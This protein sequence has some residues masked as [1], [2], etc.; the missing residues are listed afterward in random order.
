MRQLTLATLL[1]GGLLAGPLLTPASAVTVEELFSLKANGLSDDILMA[2]IES[3]GSV[4][5][6]LPEDVVTLYRRGLSERVILTMIGTSRR[7][8]QSQAEAETV[9]PIRTQETVVQP[10]QVM[11][12][13]SPVE[14]YVP[15][16]VPVNVYVPV[17]SRRP[18]RSHQPDRSTTFWGFGGQLRPDAWAQPRQREPEKNREPDRGRKDDDRNPAPPARRR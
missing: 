6:L 7:V 16:A 2:L 4:F 11:N 3:D 10:V 17:E 9:T 15:V 13:S 14:V 18:D 8:H 1:A 5:E 12:H